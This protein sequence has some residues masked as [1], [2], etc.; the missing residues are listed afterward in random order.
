M[1][2]QASHSDPDRYTKPEL[3]D[4][5]KEEVTQ[6]DKGGKPGQW[7]A[8]KAQLVTHEYEQKGGGYKQAP[9][10]EQKS[11][12]KWGE[13]KWR[14]EDGK[15]A[16]RKGGTTRYLPGKAWDSLSKGERTATNRKKQEGSKEG[17]QFVANTKEAAAARKSATGKSAT[18]KKSAAKKAAPAKE[19]AATKSKSA[20][21]KRS[22]SG[23][24]PANKA[25]AKKAPAKKTAAKKAPAKKSASKKAAPRAKARRAL[26]SNAPPEQ[27]RGKSSAL[28]SFLLQP[29]T[30]PACFPSSAARN[31]SRASSCATFV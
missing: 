4:K 17:A 9:G 3:R 28:A 22:P 18:G 8:R 15:K 2:K 23:K 26:V 30:Q 7:S 25:P 12:K 29:T 16:E 27:R 1:V 14:T 31:T 19:A 13:E 6:G 11:L 5:V 20:T 10:K 21:A 24:A